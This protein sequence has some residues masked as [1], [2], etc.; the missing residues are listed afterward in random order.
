MTW[1]DRT[2]T[3]ASTP[4]RIRGWYRDHFTP[5]HVDVAPRRER[6]KRGVWSVL[7]LVI[8]AIPVL[9]AMVL[10]VQ[11]LSYPPLPSVVN[12]LV[13]IVVFVV[14]VVLD[15]WVVFPWGVDRFD[16]VEP[17]QFRDARAAEGGGR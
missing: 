8:A 11:W 2:R 7:S 1:S 6:V 10:L 16:L 14:V 5:D 9:G 15:A 17:W 12:T 4:T 3:L 13:A